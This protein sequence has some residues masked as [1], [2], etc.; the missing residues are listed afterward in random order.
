MHLQAN[1]PPRG[2]QAGRKALQGQEIRPKWLPQCRYPPWRVPT[3]RAIP[4]NASQR[5]VLCRPVRLRALGLVRT[6]QINLIWWVDSAPLWQHPTM[7][8]FAHPHAIC[9]TEA[10]RPAL[11]ETFYQGACT[12]AVAV[13]TA[14]D[15]FLWSAPLWFHSTVFQSRWLLSEQSL[16]R[17]EQHSPSIPSFFSAHPNPWCD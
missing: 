4:L 12:Q 10:L 13:P 1:W 7:F 11:N 16:L 2:R 6:L 14:C 5:A 15:W 8:W 3:C 17:L 9:T